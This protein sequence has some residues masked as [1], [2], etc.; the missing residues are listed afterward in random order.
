M[1]PAA[2]DE[3]SASVAHLFSESPRGYQALAGQAAA[4][5]AQFVQHLSGSAQ[6]YT[7]AEA[8]NAAALQP[9]A[10]ITGSLGGIQTQLVNA[11]NT[12][13]E[14]I[15][16]TLAGFWESV[17][18]VLY[19]LVFIVWFLALLVAWAYYLQGGGQIPPGG[20]PI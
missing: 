8:A 9:L 10:A 20:F 16:N 5:H 7:A 19:D 3:V 14:Q 6:A 4:F 2:A 17:K 13:V 1:L 18:S 11:F 12:T 15:T